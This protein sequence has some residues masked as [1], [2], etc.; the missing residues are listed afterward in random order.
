M[1]DNAFDLPHIVLWGPFFVS[2]SEGY[3]HF[4]TIVD[5][6]T[7]VSWV[8][9]L[10]IKSEVLQVFPG[11]LKMIENQ[12]QT[13]VKAVRSDKSP[14]LK[15]AELFRSNGIQSFHSCPETPQQ[16]SV[17]ERKHQHILNMVRALMFQSHLPL[18]FWGDC[19]LTA[20]F[21]IDRISTPL[22]NNKSLFQMLT[23]KVPDY[24]GLQV[25]G[26]L[27]YYSTSSKKR[28]KF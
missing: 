6:H 1:R 13:T 21:L 12:F 17:V 20:V 19:I 24:R 3:K 9:L 8:Y 22:L 27:L 26:C 18:E 23:S 15:F 10:R 25:F 2:T 28:H 4:L 16:N 5:D 7:R 11:F 14:E